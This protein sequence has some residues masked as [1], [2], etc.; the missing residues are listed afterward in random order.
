MLWAVVVGIGVGAALGT[1]VGRLVLYLRRTHKEAVGLDDFLALGLIGLAYGVAQPRA[2][3]RLPRRVRGRRRACG[4]SSSTPARRGTAAEAP[5]PPAK[6][7]A[8]RRRSADVAAKAHAHP[9]VSLAE[10]VATDPQHAPAYM[11]HAVLSFNEQIERIAE[12][13]AVIA[14]GTLL[15]AVDWHRASWPFVRLAAARHPADLGGRR[16][17]GLEDLA[18]RSAA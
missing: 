8:R 15:W 11:A 7:E 6:A 4:A 12:V 2:R 3:L 10:Q 13:V 16:P 1:L 14:V 17:G 9:D 18:C 5:A